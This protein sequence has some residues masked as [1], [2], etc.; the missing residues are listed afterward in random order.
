MGEIT[1]NV[2]HFAG[3]PLG[4]PKTPWGSLERTLRTT[5]TR[6]EPSHTDPTPLYSIAEIYPHI[7]KISMIAEVYNETRCE[8]V[9]LLFH[10]LKY[11]V[12][13][14][15]IQKRNCPPLPIFLPAGNSLKICI[16]YVA[17]KDTH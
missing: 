10:Y 15:V 8:L 9:D 4:P 1:L 14:R 13:V 12:R 6:I 16:Q 5:V 17:P 3:E 7:I 2:L 11:I